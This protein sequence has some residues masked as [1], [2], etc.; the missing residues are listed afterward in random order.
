MKQ[1]IQN[2][3]SGRLELAEVPP[4]VCSAGTLLVQNQASFVSLGTERSII[5]LGKK[6]LMGKAKARPDLVKRFMDKAKKEGF[7]KTFKEALDRLDS[8]TSLGYSAAGTVIEAGGNVHKY[9]PGDRI[10][11]I[12]A[13]YAA[14]AEYISVPENLVCKIPP[15]LSWAEASSGMLGIIALH[16]IRCTQSHAGEIVAVIGLGLLG[17]LSL[18]ILRAY[19]FKVI[20]MDVDNEK[21]AIARKLGIDAVYTAG[22]EFKNA[23]DRIS[24]GHGADA[25]IITAST[26]SDAPVNTA[27]DLARYGGKIVIVGVADIHPQRNEMWHKEVEIIVS[28]AGGPGIFDPLYENQGIDYPIGYIRW[29]QNRNLEEYLRLLSENKV[30]VNPLI[31]H[32]FNFENAE[33]VYADMLA[34][35]G[36][37]YTGVVFSYPETSHGAP[38]IHLSRRALSLPEGQKNVGAQSG[39]TLRV[40]VVGAGLFGRSLLLPALKNTANV[41]LKA[42]ATSTGANTYHIGKKYGF[43]EIT[44]DFREVL[45][46]SDIDAVVILTPHSRHAS[47]VVEALNC[48]KHIFVEKPLCVNRA[49]LDEIMTAYQHSKT[50]G[51]LILQVGYNRRFSPHARKAAEAL[52]DR[53]DPI[54]INYRVNAGFVPGDHWV[55]SPE[56]G[57]SRVIGEICHFVDLMQYLCGCDP[58]R[59][60]AD[61]ISANNKT[62]LNSDNLAVTLKFSDGSVGNIVYSAG[63]DKAF[64]R[65]R[66]EIFWEGKTIV[67]D[68][69]R[70]SDFYFAGKKKSYKTIN[71]Q[72]GYKE[73]LRHFCDTARNV[74]MPVLTAGESFVSTLCVFKIN[75]ALETGQPCEVF[76]SAS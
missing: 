55:H 25:V 12:G 65:E 44:T 6:S 23:V 60:F 29:T 49:E 66:A 40:G 20:G 47:M 2:Y 15:N 21:I 9:S 42:I 63:G 43:Q 19:G 11:C 30:A 16:G 3:R 18:Q 54:V 31:S 37:P 53:H 24:N 39:N 10:A 26:Q 32:Q 68:D 27:V 1:L 17:L 69:Y 14:H 46:D 36:G 51:H 48:G 4:P 61:R 33:T 38:A 52:Q 57:G 8:P 64:S 76:L 50:G 67:I 70:K 41:S 5:E 22:G 72:M 28:K 45:A 35:R 59:V 71:Q 34:N 73:E 58:V 7:V 74:I 62:S 56:E 75:Q 13:G